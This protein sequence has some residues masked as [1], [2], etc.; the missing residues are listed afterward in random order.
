MKEV[1]EKCP[2][3][4]HDNYLLRFVEID[5]AKDLLKVYSDEK[6]V[7]YFNSD[8]CHGDNFYYKTLERMQDVIKYWIWEYDRKGFVRWSIIDKNS[9]EAVGTIELFHRVSKD[10]FDACGLLRLDLRSDYENQNCVNAILS[11]II[12]PT[13]DLFHCNMIATKAA[14]FAM[15]RIHALKGMGFHQSEDKLLGHDGTEYGDYWVCLK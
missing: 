8:N 5:D 9:N 1:Y 14:S 11:I 3:L 7:P 13:Y 2:V 15:E 6:A 12:S 10:Y 4:A